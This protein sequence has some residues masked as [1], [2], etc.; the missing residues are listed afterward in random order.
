MEKFATVFHLNHN[1]L[2]TNVFYTFQV[3]E[4]VFNILTPLCIF[5]PK[6]FHFFVEARYIF[7]VQIMNDDKLLCLFFFTVNL[8]MMS[9]LRLSYL[10][11][12]LKST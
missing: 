2:C 7:Q 3:Y 5:F 10:F 9:L 1:E 6:F 8:K 11:Q 12:K 4:S